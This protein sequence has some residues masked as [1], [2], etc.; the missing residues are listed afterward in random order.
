M[1]IHMSKQN[2]VNILPTFSKTSNPWC[3]SITAE[4]RSIL[5]QVAVYCSL[6]LSL[7]LS[8]SPL[9]YFPLPLS[10][11]LYFSLLPLFISLSS[12]LFLDPPLTFYICD[13]N[14]VSM[15]FFFSLCLTLKNY[16]SIYHFL[17]LYFFISL[18]LPHNLLFV[19][20]YF[21]N[22]L[23]FLL[24]CLYFFFLCTSLISKFN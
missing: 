7:S 14:F 16:L 10:L 22:H 19:Y 23:A 24:L 1:Y 13:S 21:S 2:Y 5:L 18:L 3:Y 9:F 15:S 20:L 6:S 4:K 12:S 8:H 11:T 17:T